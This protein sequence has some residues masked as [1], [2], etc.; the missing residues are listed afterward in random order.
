MVIYDFIRVFSGVPPL[1]WKDL[2]FISL[3]TPNC[4]RS[5]LFLQVN[6]CPWSKRVSFSRPRNW[7][8]KTVRPIWSWQIKMAGSLGTLELE[9]LAR[10][11]RKGGMVSYSYVFLRVAPI[12]ILKK[13][14]MGSVQ[15]PIWQWYTWTIQHGELS[16]VSW[17]S[18]L[19][20]QMRYDDIYWHIFS[21]NKHGLC[22]FLSIHFSIHE[23]GYKIVTSYQTPTKRSWSQNGHHFSPNVIKI[24]L[25]PQS[26]PK[27]CLGNWVT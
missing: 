9:F 6:G 11:L 5:I 18:A 4:W 26:T 8:P 23:T 20:I 10:F 17:E 16:V 12:E 13:I 25:K 19:E 15:T 14:W 27:N 3:L 1:F 24:V 22:S 7:K 2:W 21:P